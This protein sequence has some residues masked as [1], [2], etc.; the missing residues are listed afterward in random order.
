MT[1]Q[2]TQ[3]AHRIVVGIDFTDACRQAL[4]DALRLAARMPGTEV[5]VA[6]VLDA[7]VERASQIAKASDRMVEAEKKLASF[8]RESAK[9][10]DAHRTELPIVYHVRIGKPA[11]AL[12]QV[13]FDVD[14]ELIVVGT[15]ARS[16]AAKL[17][18]GSVGEDL[19]RDG[20][21]PVLV[22][23]ARDTTGMTRS[24]MPEPRRPGEALTGDRDSMLSSN[25][26]VDFGSRVSRISG[27]I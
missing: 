14:A 5:H 4:L 10:A 25:D 12:N 7:S 3:T 17:L 8:V 2:T 11:A 22:S 26:R 23:R 24:S 18:L 1:T 16:R 27:L 15:R 21:F 9:A 13:A 19:L 20:H 6:T